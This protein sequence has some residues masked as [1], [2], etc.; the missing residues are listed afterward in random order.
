MTPYGR[1]TRWWKVKVR[2]EGRFLIGGIV[3]T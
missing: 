2:H 3:A 1:A